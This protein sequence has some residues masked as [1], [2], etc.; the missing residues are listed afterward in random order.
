MVM[1]ASGHMAAQRAQPV[2]LASGAGSTTG[3]PVSEISPVKRSDLCGHAV[4]QSP[5]PLQYLAEMVTLAPIVRVTLP[6]HLLAE[7][8]EEGALARLDET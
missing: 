4:M 7:H 8:L 2:H 1:A 3:S 6:V 5:Q